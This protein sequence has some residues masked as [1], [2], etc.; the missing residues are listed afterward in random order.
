MLRRCGLTQLIA[1]R[2]GALPVVRATG[3]LADTVHDVAKGARSHSSACAIGCTEDH[4]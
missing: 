1:L 4:S 3:G 2:Y